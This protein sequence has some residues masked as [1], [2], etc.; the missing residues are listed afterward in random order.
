MPHII[1]LDPDV[2]RQL[3]AQHQ[4]VASDTRAWSK[5]PIDWLASFP[6]TYGAIADPVYKALNTY[7][8]ARE[9]AGEALAQEHDE[10][11]RQLIK[12]ANDFEN[13][14]N[15][16]ANLLR[17]SGQDLNQPSAT[18]PPAGPLP[19]GP[20]PAGPLPGD[21][22]P[23]A[24]MSPPTPAPGGPTS[25]GPEHPETSGAPTPGGAQDPSVLQPTGAAP[26]TSGAVMPD[27]G[28]ED[29][30]GVVGTQ[31]TSPSAG[32][33][34]AAGGSVL[35][36][37]GGSLYGAADGGTSASSAGASGRPDGQPPVPSAV[38]MP[39]SMTT[40]FGEAVAAAKAKE[41]E[42]AY[43]VGD[44]VNADLVLAR[45]LLGSVLA[46]VDSP[47][48]MTWAVS[49]MRGPAG[50]GI[51]ITS[52]EG[53]GWMPAKLFLP[54][55]VSTPWLWDELLG[56]DSADNASPWEGVSDPARV[57]AEFGLAWGGKANAQLSALVSSGPI[58][59]GLRARFPDA[60]MD[61]LVA[62]VYDVDLRVFTPDTADRLGLTG[63]VPALERVAAIDDSQVR[64][65]CVE[66]AA[67]ANARLQRSGPAPVAALESRRLRERILSALQSGT[68]VPRQLWDEFRDADDL[69]AASMLSQRVDVGRVEV[70][71]LR[72]D[73]EV[74]GLRAMV[75]DRRCNELVL[76]L[77]EES[78]RQSLRDAVYA[79]EQIV[80]HPQFVDTPAAVITAAPER[81]SRPTAAPGA[82]TASGVT[83]GPP[84]GAVA[85]P[86][87]TPPVVPRVVVPEQP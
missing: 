85:A 2:L 75:F 77:A 57:L 14:D 40:P 70:G 55:E 16:I 32:A 51:F 65:N 34:S 43:V 61:G 71:Q 30:S 35:P 73:S 66:L 20:L 11:A 52:N 81:V 28:D 5:P 39:V 18:P 41:A 27:A 21:T 69:L 78:T 31:S 24:P 64:A 42:P 38:P 36:P 80:E 83:A 26:G 9:R 49:V 37:A 60:A 44:Q 72:V 13:N 74:S 25:V 12:A 53:R 86:A 6:G 68:T 3:A 8:E 58:D 33:T 50:A 15:E 17:K 84:S 48:G 56:E 76:L 59:P 29:T 82:V 87:E 46:A 62:P 19:A 67:D 7:Y 23:N 1:D 10:T 79:H 54:R 47:V 63:S 22:D 4:R 45:T